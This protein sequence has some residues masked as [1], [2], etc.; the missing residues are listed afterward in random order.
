LGIKSNV[1]PEITG[2]RNATL[3]PQLLF[4]DLGHHKILMWDEGRKL[5]MCWNK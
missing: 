5:Q 1:I 4:T 2:T 3:Q